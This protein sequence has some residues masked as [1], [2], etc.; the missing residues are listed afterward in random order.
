MRIFISYSSIDTNIVSVLADQLKMY[1]DV[2]Y[3]NKDKAPGETA[4]EQIY[5][6]IDNSDIVL[7]LVTD[8]TVAR[9]ISVGQEVGR[10]KSGNKFIIPMVSSSVSKKG[11]GFLSDIKYQE[12]DIINPAPAIN[13]IIDLID[14]KNKTE[15]QK[16]SL[17]LVTIGFFF[18]LL[19]KK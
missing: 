18:W 11:L 6:W 15:I 14:C 19:N 8:A 7:V 1:G 12:I 10:A 3:W 2:Y 5:S 9:A 4:W 13:R 16:L 17:I